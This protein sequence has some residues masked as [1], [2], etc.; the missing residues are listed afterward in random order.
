MSRG[1]RDHRVRGGAQSCPAD[2][3]AARRKRS[4]AERNLSGIA[5][6]V[7]DRF[8]RHAE[9]LRDE[10]RER[11]LVALAVRMGAGDDRH[12]AARDRT[13]IPCGR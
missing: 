7:L 10:L 4:A 8:E 11:G 12:L 2:H 6:D 1:L 3:R 5:L 9:P 13:A